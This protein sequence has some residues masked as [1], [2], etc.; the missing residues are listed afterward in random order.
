MSDKLGENTHTRTCEW[1]AK[2]IPEKAIKCPHCH[3][4]RKDIERDRNAAYVLLP[5]SILMLAIGAS[6]F[7][8]AWNQRSSRFSD[9]PSEAPWHEAVRVPPPPPPPPA[10][11]LFAIPVAYILSTFPPEYHYYFSIQKFLGS[12]QGWVVIM[13]GLYAIVV[14]SC[15]GFRFR[16]LQRK[17]G[18][19][20]VF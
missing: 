13:N 16:N 10:K 1:C 4:L 9:A 2:C 19:W 5:A 14:F 3:K 12:V 18:T 15:A 17:T 8:N 7:V 6:V 20:W 11:T